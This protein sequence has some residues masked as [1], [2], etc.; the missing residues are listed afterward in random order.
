MP[1]LPIGLSLLLVPLQPWAFYMAFPANLT[2]VRGSRIKPYEMVDK[3]IEALTKD[4]LDEVAQKVKDLHKQTVEYAV[5]RADF[6]AL[7]RSGI[8]KEKLNQFHK[9]F[10]NSMTYP[11]SMVWYGG[12]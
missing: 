3:P 11:K 12:K 6:K 8:T 7:T 2:Y 5:G 4:D 9:I 10:Q 1:F